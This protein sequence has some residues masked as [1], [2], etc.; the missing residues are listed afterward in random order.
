MLG[1][2]THVSVN[3]VYQAGPHPVI[4]LECRVWVANTLPAVSHKI[5]EEAFSWALSVPLNQSLLITDDNEEA[6]AEQSLWTYLWRRCHSRNDPDSKAEKEKSPVS[7]KECVEKLFALL[8]KWNFTPLV[9]GNVFGLERL[10]EVKPQCL[11]KSQSP[12]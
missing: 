1:K 2:K 9:L 10:Q 6:S 11:P 5:S 8:C 3:A 12:H 4:W 7:W